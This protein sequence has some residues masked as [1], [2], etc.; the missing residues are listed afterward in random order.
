MVNLERDGGYGREKGTTPL[1]WAHGGSE[2]AL[3]AEEKVAHQES[4]GA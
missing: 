3:L 1:P 2:G 4:E